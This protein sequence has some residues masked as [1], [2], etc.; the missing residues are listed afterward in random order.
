[1]NSITFIPCHPDH[2]SIPPAV[3]GAAQAAF[4]I[5]ESSEGQNLRKQLQ[6]NMKL[7]RS[8]MKRAG[9]TLKVSRL[10]G[11]F[12]FTVQGDNHPIT[13]IMLGDA[14]LASG[15]A[16][17]MLKLGVYVIGFSYP[18]VPQ[19]EARIRVQL[20]A[21]HSKEDVEKAIEAFIHVGKKHQVIS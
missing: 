21:S 16:D 5:V 14:R 3:V 13:P 4:D 2:V 19:G 10:P 15:F 17:D 6:D 18:V 7:F 12:N 11:P 8:E 9:F 1:M 20:S